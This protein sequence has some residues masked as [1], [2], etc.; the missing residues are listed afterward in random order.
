MCQAL[1]EVLETLVSHRQDACPKG[2][3]SSVG[4]A[5]TKQITNACII[6]IIVSVLVE[7]NRMLWERIIWI[8]DGKMDNKWVDGDG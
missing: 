5:D 1:Y 4:E 3:C 8:S 6:P 7:K 2:A